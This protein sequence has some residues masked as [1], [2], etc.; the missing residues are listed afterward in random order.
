M[1]YIK[2][3]VARGWTVDGGD[4]ILHRPWCGTPPWLGR[5]HGAPTSHVA[6]RPKHKA[7]PRSHHPVFHH[8]LHMRL[9]PCCERVT[10]V[11]PRCPAGVV[12]DR[13]SGLQR[14]PVARAGRGPALTSPPASDRLA[15]ASWSPQNPL[16]LDAVCS[17]RRFARSSQ[18]LQAAG[19][20]DPNFEDY[21]GEAEDW[22]AA[23]GAD[24]GAQGQGM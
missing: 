19:G 21:F 14:L 4:P 20:H 24:A 18:R 7:Q 15:F 11:G 5:P 23:P 6:S 17:H 16:R 3:L 13:A 2:S 22:A 12:L 10:P 1:E 9:R 8:P